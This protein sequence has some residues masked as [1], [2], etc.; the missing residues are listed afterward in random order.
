M[1][2]QK[3]PQKLL[4]EVELWAALRRDQGSPAKPA[5][6]RLHKELRRAH[7]EL[8]VMKPGKVSRRCE[9]NKLAAI[10]KLRQKG[11]RKIWRRYQPRG[12][13][14][15]LRGAW[16]GRA[17]GC[18]LGVPVENWDIAA[19]EALAAESGM[20]FPPEDYWATHPEPE[21]VRYGVT[22]VREYLKGGIRAV[23]VDDD[24]AY[25]V[26]GLLILEEFGPDFTTQ[27][28]AKAW[29]AHLP[30]ACTAEGVALENLRDGVPAKKTGAVNNP[31]QE[32]IGADIRCDP[33][34]YAAPG[35]PAR[36]AEMAYRDAYLT[37]R[38]NGI[39][40][41][42]FFAAALSA[43]F[44]VDDPVAAL[45]IGLTEIPRDSRLAQA[46][47]WALGRAPNVK[48]FREARTLVDERFPDMHPVHTINNA[49][50]TIFGLALGKG[51]F[52]RTIGV[53]VAMGLDNDC[54]AA[55]AGSILGAVKGAR[56]IPPHW[57]RPFRNK[58]RTYLKGH[59]SFANTDLV[60]RFQAAAQ[61]TWNP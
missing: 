31:F 55:T 50:L 36:A 27:D 60:Q 10:R 2:Q 29:L 24:L 16:L 20:A 18:T 61:R 57:W 51:D 44:A 40:G 34:A 8:E 39:Y 13:P 58:I 3:D 15:R 7:D 33:W 21:I 6:K 45:E 9:P 12:L 37:H 52:S 25:T 5:L 53:T 48:D 32:W 17:A 38:Q 54:T 14:T 59:E 4:E 11:P 19:M 56:A 47:R 1:A 35:W 41:A 46:V 49:C 23:P 22:P 43:A 28:V 26:L 42:M 30:M